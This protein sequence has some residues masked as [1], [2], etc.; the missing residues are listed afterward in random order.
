MIEPTLSPEN[1]VGTCATCGRPL[2]QRGPNGECLRCLVSLALGGEDESASGRLA[3]RQRTTPGPLRYAHF[4]IEVGSDGFPVELGWGAMAVTYRARDT[5]LNSVVALKVIDRTIAE[6][7]TARARFLREARAAAQL[8]HPNVARV[9][10]YGEQDGECFYVMELVEGETLEARVRRDG[11]MPLALALEVME[12]AARALAA[13]EACGVVHRDIKPSNLMIESE[14]SGSILLKVI[15]YGVAK[16]TTLQT[17]TGLDQTQAGFVA[18]PAFAS[19]EQFTGAS[20]IKVDSRSDIYSLGITL[21]Y[22]LSGRTPFLGRTLEE[23]RAR[24]S[25]ELPVEQLRNADVPPSVLAL[26]KSMLALDPA[27]RPQSARELVSAVHRCYL[28]FEPHTRSRRKHRFVASGIAA[29]L[30]MAALI[31]TWFYKRASSIAQNERS[32]AVLPFENLSPDKGD[33]FFTVGMQDEIA[34]ELSRLANLKTIGPQSTRPYLP[35]TH[36]NLSAIGRELG[37]RHLLEGS[38]R[39]GNGNMQVSLRLVDLHDPQRPWAESY[40]R[41]VE[42]I[43]AL[44]NEMTRAV[45]AQLETRLSSREKAALNLPPTNDVEAYELYLRAR[46]LTSSRLEMSIA[47]LFT[48]GKQAISMLNQAVARDPNFA[49]AYCELAKWHDELYFQRNVGPPE[50]QAIDHRSLADIALEKARRLEP[51][52]GTLHLELA[53]HALQINRDTEQAGYEIERAR[54]T[55]PNNA[56]VETIAGRVARRADRW[57]EALHYLERAVSLEPREAN[58]RILLA[59]SYRCMRRYEDFDRLIVSAIALTPSD[60]LGTL[61]IHRALGR[62][63]SSADMAALRTAFTEQLAA[64]QLDDADKAS[65]EMNIAVWSHDADAIRRFLTTK[66]EAVS[67]NGVEYPDAWFEALAARMRGDSSAALR[68]FAAARTPMEN[69]AASVPSE[70]VPLSILAI[71]DAGLGR[72]ED[73][74]QEARRACDLSSFQTNN[75]DATTVRCNLAVVYAW[76]GE[77]DLANTELSKLI[78]RAASSHVVCQPTYGDFRL[79]PFWDPLR[80]DPR[81]TAIVEKLAPSKSQQ[82]QLH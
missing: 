53:L 68:A 24:Q 11:P 43:F 23:L 47:Q 73:A 19:P 2:T 15:D 3:T 66:H 16:V 4:Q 44:R 64:H 74:L 76:T 27:D 42:E 65:A 37:V 67:F 82:D 22:L 75:F 13:A 10:H 41:P 54:Q 25:N 51:D 34:A 26:L 36:R 18:T 78:E 46:T 38:V 55:L 77:N 80:S 50:E 21:W 57:D 7:S 45:A 79:N 63:E 69:R 81:F 1:V 40:Q 31:G 52:S 35:G 20:Q 8:H 32:V 33:A 12:Q 6:N 56:Q 30:L 71:I 62:L 28:R 39:R 29:L 60:K 59:D 58:L 17:E 72:K 5:V 49:L 70:G 14:A 61:P 48:D 9:T